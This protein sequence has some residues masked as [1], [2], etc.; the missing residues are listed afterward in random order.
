M[1]TPKQRKEFY[2]LYGPIVEEQTKGTGLYPQVILAQLAL[3]SAYG[4]AKSAKGNLGGRKLPQSR[5]SSL[6]KGVDYEIKKTR[7]NFSTKAEADAF[8]KQQK[9]LG[10]KVYGTPSQIKYGNEFVVR[11]EQPFEISGDGSAES[12]VQTQIDFLLKTPTYKKNGVFNATSP[13]EQAELLKKAGYATDANYASKIE[14]VYKQN[15]F[16][17]YTTEQGID[18]TIEEIDPTID[19]SPEDIVNTLSDEEF[20]QIYQDLLASDAATAKDMVADDFAMPTSDAY[21]NFLTEREDVKKASTIEQLKELDSGKVYSENIDEIERMLNNLWMRGDYQVRGEDAPSVFSNSPKTRMDWLAEKAPTVEKAIQPYGG[22]GQRFKVDKG[23]IKDNI[24][25]ILDELGQITD[26]DSPLSYGD[27]LYEDPYKNQQP[28]TG[29][30]ES[31]FVD[32]RFQPGIQGTPPDA[33]YPLVNDDF[34]PGPQAQQFLERRQAY[35]NEISDPDIPEEIE[36]DDADEDYSPFVGPP[37][38]SID[39]SLNPNFVGPPEFSGEAL[40]KKGYEERPTTVDPERRKPNLGN[41]DYMGMLTD[42]GSY[43][44]RMAPLGRALGDANV[45]DQVRYPRL[46]PTLPTAHAQRNEINTAFTTAQQAARKQGKLDLGALSALATQQA[47]TV[48]GVEENVANERIGL[49]NQAQQLNN[50]VTMQEMADTA[51]NKGAAA[52][53]R[54]QALAAMSQMGQG[55]L[56]EM[57]MRRNDANVKKMFEDVFDEKWEQ[58]NQA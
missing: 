28:E 18:P 55:S 30:P 31:D 36:P 51:A 41:T 14:N 50:Q 4:T 17:Q 42:I 13:K 54:Y 15:D 47:K 22:E 27:R 32:P 26:E 52:T 10:Y 46:N 40:V 25:T 12:N 39:D 43:A 35:L 45:Y 44:A 5:I 33:V 34:I 6:E 2:E 38:M 11:L 16:P 53:M 57:N 20:Q 8:A 37:E 21:N 9:D 1:A 7:E 56:R 23:L 58:Y 19:P 24:Y 49:I 48:A 29:I 3:E